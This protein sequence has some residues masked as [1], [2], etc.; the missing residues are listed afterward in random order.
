MTRKRKR[1]D[2]IEKIWEKRRESN[3]AA[4]FTVMGTADL[5]QYITLFQ[6]GIKYKSITDSYQPA[7]G[8]CLSL[9]QSKMRDGLL[10]FSKLIPKKM[11]K[12]LVH[13][14]I[15]HVTL[16]CAAMGGHLEL[17]KWLYKNTPF[18]CSSD[19]IDGAASNGFL[20][21]IEWLWK[22]K[23]R[24]F[25]PYAMEIAARNGHYKI[26]EWLCARPNVKPSAQ[27]FEEA[28]ANG[29]LDIIKLLDEYNHP[30]SVHG[31]DS[32]AQYGHLE[33][34]KYLDKEH[35]EGCTVFAMDMAAAKNHLEVVKY[36]HANRTEGCT[37]KAID[38][39]A[40]NGHIDIVVFLDQNRIEGSTHY[41][42]DWACERGDL[43]MVEYLHDHD[44]TCSPYALDMACKNKHYKVAK[45]MLNIV[46][47]ECRHDT[48][49]WPA[50]NNDLKTLK[51]LHK[52]VKPCPT[53]V[54]D[55]AAENGFLEIVE[56]LVNVVKAPCTTE[57]MDNAS[58]HGYI[59][60]VILLH[61]SGAMC[62]K[63]ALSS[64]ILR[65][66]WKVVDFL[67]QYR[68]E[69]CDSFVMQQCVLRGLMKAVIW[70][71]FNTSQT[72]SYD[73]LDKARCGGRREIVAFM[74]ERPHRLVYS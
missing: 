58:Y 59:K 11:D 71:Y 28:C 14:R 12:K 66:H 70:L 36:L 74:E 65:S 10:V 43:K 29:H 46:K 48:M 25:T 38:H 33:V 21:V 47:A 68:T 6:K 39:A 9:F 40:L 37:T 24:K 72:I 30:C 17:L 45:Y 19:A 20:E 60:I 27:P 49:V 15:S 26:V 62:S 57:A 41:A 73:T 50:K 1:Q 42:M 55:R 61:E 63:F 69:G 54:L 51:L 4:F 7:V 34:V 22:H 32:A 18:V 13:L 8:G 64:A 44:H 35:E 67:Y 5:F 53:E 2:S 23:S 52:H 16:D 3:E 56:Y 31:M